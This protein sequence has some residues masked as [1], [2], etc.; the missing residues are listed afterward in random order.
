MRSAM[1]AHWG[2]TLDLS[3][4]KLHPTASMVICK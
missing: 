1:T 2:R 4:K 3:H